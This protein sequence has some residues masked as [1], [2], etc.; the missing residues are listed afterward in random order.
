MC[1]KGLTFSDQQIFTSP[2]ILKNIP[3]PV[4]N[5]KKSRREPCDRQNPNCF[6]LRN[7]C[8]TC[9]KKYRI[10]VHHCIFQ[11]LHFLRQLPNPLLICD[12]CPV[13]SLS[14]FVR[15]HMSYFC[16]TRADNMTYALLLFMHREKYFT[17][18]FIKRLV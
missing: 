8:V 13:D 14:Y 11:L 15:Q 17:K 9:V 10:T 7:S 16:A 6:H 4:H 18:R 12:S 3:F 2:L 1:M 5:I